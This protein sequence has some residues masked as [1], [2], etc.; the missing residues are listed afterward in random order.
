M[1][2]YN[3]IGKLSQVKYSLLNF[4]SKNKFK[5][6]LIGFLLV[7]F[8]LTGVFTALKISDLE[9]AIKTA[10]FSFEAITNGDIYDFSFLIK[11]FLSFLLVVA[12]LFV[13]SLNKYI[14]IFG[15]ILICYRAYLVALNCTLIIRYMGIGGVINSIVII[16]PC[17][18]IQLVLI[19]IMF[20][21]FCAIRKYKKECGIY[22][23]TYNKYI[24]YV[25]I[26]SLLVNIIELLLLIIF[27]ATTILIIWQF[28]FF[29]YLTKGFGFC[30]N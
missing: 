5:I 20:L 4:Y 1:I 19:S 14:N 16:L 6:L 21:I 13:F 11:R 29:M 8:L 18:I 28:C 15:Y 17:Q 10:E 26:S 22:N 24:L 2:N 3:R 7:V 27:K 12:L 25:L 23:K 9:K 30:Y